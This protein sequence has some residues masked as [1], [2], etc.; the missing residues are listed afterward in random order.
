MGRH[1]YSMAGFRVPPDPQRDR[2][3]GP[4]VDSR[5]LSTLAG[6]VLAKVRVP[7]SRCVVALSGG[8]D[9]AICAWVVVQA[10]VL[11]RALHVDHGL[12]GSPV[13]RGGAVAIAASLGIPL[14]IA[15]VTVGSGPSPE[16]LARTARY[17]A[18][19]A[20]L[21]QDEVLLTGHTRAD[22]AETILGNLLRGTGADGLAGIPRRRGRIVRPL[23]D[24][25]S[26]THLRAH[27]TVLDL[28]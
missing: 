3:P 25:V 12:P 16:G 26:Y 13:V 4:M 14:Q 28:V 1:Q 8:P 27:E 17:E 20:S 11:V 21:D 23:L 15:E 2:R 9:S 7:P 6:T 24:A 22:Q 10:G 18:L 19:E 5:R